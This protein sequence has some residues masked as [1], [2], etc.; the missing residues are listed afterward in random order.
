MNPFTMILA[1]H[2]DSGYG[3]YPTEPCRSGT[4]RFLKP[5]TQVGMWP[6]T[7]IAMCASALRQYGPSKLIDT[8]AASW[9]Q[10]LGQ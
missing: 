1:E 8:M 4:Q 5:H 9:T 2:Y 7:S 3:S 10:K 6:A